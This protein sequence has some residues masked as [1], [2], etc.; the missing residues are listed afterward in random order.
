MCVC[1]CVCVCVRSF[2]SDSATPRTDC[3][4]PGFPVH[5]V[6]LVKILESVA[7]SYSR[8]IFPTREPNL[9]PSVSCTGRRVLYHRVTWEA[10]SQQYCNA[11]LKIAKTVDLKSTH[12]EK[13]NN[14]VVME[15]MQ[16]HIYTHTYI[17]L[18]K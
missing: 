16:I 12:H 18:Y 1:V 11:H 2:V 17:S 4:L 8:G 9:F 10:H 3:G 5:G 13:K 14:C 15:V 7:I 6:F